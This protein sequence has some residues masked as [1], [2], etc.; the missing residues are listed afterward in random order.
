MANIPP[1]S[2]NLT[3]CLEVIVKLVDIGGMLA[4]TV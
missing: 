1:I 3:D 4:M 2:T